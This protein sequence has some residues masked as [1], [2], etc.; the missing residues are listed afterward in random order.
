MSVA[1]DMPLLRDLGARV[2]PYLRSRDKIS[3]MTSLAGWTRSLREFPCTI[4]QDMPPDRG[5]NCSGM[6]PVPR[7][8]AGLFLQKQLSGYGGS[9]F[10]G[11]SSMHRTEDPTLQLRKIAYAAETLARH[12]IAG[13]GLQNPSR[14]PTDFGRGTFWQGR[15]RPQ[16]FALPVLG[17]DRRVHSGIRPERTQAMT[18]SSFKPN[19]RQTRSPSAAQT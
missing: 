8:P 19:G 3:S 13:V 16:R 2:S 12:Q 11:L 15:A 10:E 5:A 1:S 9:V 6:S 7:S 17:R 14:P 4:R 18:G